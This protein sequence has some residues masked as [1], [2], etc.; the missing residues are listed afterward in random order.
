MAIIKLPAPN[1]NVRLMMMMEA[2]EWCTMAKAL[3]A[4]NYRSKFMHANNGSQMNEQKKQQRMA[5]AEW[6]HCLFLRS[7]RSDVHR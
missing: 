6:S 5:G 4:A 7:L 3:L 2:A 1:A